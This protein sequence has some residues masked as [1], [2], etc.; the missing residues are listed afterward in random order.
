MYRIHAI[1]NHKARTLTISSMYRRKKVADGQKGN[2]LAVKLVDLAKIEN[3]EKN[4][5]NKKVY[6]FINNANK[7]KYYYNHA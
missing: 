1:K 7:A 6:Q 4:L 3:L 2:F 5:T